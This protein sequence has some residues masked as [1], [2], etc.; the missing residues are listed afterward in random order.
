MFGS[1]D[2]FVRVAVADLPAAYEAFLSR[3]VLTIPRIKNV[4]SHFTMKT[5]KPGP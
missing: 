1:R 3:R 4:T 5:V 2:Y